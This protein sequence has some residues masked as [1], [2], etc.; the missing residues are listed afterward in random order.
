MHLAV[1]WLGTGNHIA[2]WRMPGAF[3]SNCSWPIVEAV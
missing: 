2:G 1:F 3:D